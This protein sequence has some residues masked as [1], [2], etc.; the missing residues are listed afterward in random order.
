MKVNLKKQ[1][2][3]KRLQQITVQ[4]RNKD[5][6]PKHIEMAE[7]GN[8]FLV[9]AYDERKS[10]II[11]E[12]ASMGMDT[13][14]HLATIKCL[15]EMAERKAFKEGHKNGLP[16]CQTE[17]TDGFAA[18]PKVFSLCDNSHAMARKNAYH[19]AVERF[20]WSTWWDDPHYTHSMIKS[21]ALT[22]SARDL[23]GKIDELTPIKKL[24]EVRPHFE[25][26]ENLVL[27]IFF[28]FLKNGG[29]ITGGACGEIRET[30]LV[31]QRALG[32]LFRHSLGVYRNLVKKLRPTTFYEK[33]L[34]YFGQGHG[35]QRVE[36][37]LY[38]KEVSFHPIELPKLAIDSEVPHSLDDVVLVHRCLFENQ[39]AFVGGKL[40]R[41]CL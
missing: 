31:K 10:D 3:Q 29:V 34:S 17:R 13:S 25:S 41:A 27:P 23:L 7:L 16:S 22:P 12:S 9:S 36:A 38:P 35:T 6:L 28:A 21:P 8:F 18:Y 20:V 26:E 5:A 11:T 24:V 39:P 32:E 14:F 40:E 15:M 2:I 33:R 30:T 37:R 4:L 1:L 19:E